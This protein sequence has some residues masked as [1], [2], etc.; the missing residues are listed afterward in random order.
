MDTK[1]IQKRQAEYDSKYWRI[2]SSE[3]E[4]IRHLTLHLVKLLGKLSDYCEKIE[5][6][7]DFST[8]Q[9]KNEVIP[10]LIFYS[11]HLSNL[12]DV[13]MAEKYIERLKKNVERLEKLSK[14]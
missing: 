7:E 13:D 14:K 12:L 10:D 8:E 5:H 3:L 4:N 2:K 6:G 9:I 11:A 1:E